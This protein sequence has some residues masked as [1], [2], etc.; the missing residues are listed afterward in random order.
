MGYKII[1]S[2]DETYFEFLKVMVKSAV[3][4]FPDAS[5]YAELINMTED[6]VKTMTDIAPQV[7]S[8]IKEVKFDTVNQRKCFCTNR[9]TELFN[10]LRNRCDDMLI[11]IDADSIVRKPCDEFKSI[12]DKHDVSAVVRPAPH[13]S[14]RG[15]IIAIN[16]T[17]GGNL[18]LERY[19]QIM[20]AEN[21]WQKVGNRPKL[22]SDGFTWRVWMANQSVLDYLCRKDKEMKRLM[23]FGALSNKFCDVHLSERGVIWAAKNKLKTSPVYLEEL[24]KYK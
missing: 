22:E 24:K 5:I 19:V 11:W 15:G 14:L 8:H 12:I 4:N 6:H 13:S 2:C 21:Q 7:E 18:F 9:R 1:S 3:V 23:K 10:K 20:K 17:K 16:N